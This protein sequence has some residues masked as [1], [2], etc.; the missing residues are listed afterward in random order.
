[1]INP[2][3]DFKKRRFIP[4]SLVLFYLILD[5]AAPVKRPIFPFWM[6]C[7]E[8]ISGAGRG[9]IAALYLLGS[10][11]FM[12]LSSGLLHREP[13]F[14]AVAI[15]FAGPNS[16]GGLVTPRLRMSVLNLLTS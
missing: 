11:Q 16:A 9:R 1:L 10:L 15:F 12:P 7:S 8:P 14:P 3:P 4:A 13:G 5:L 2:P 6:R